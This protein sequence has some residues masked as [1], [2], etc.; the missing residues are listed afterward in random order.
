MRQLNIFFLLLV[1]LLMSAC[2]GV[3][4]FERPALSIADL[5]PTK[6]ARDGQVFTLKL[7][8]DN[9]NMVALPIEG[10]DYALN[11][12]GY[13]VASG[14]SNKASRIPA[15]GSGFVEIDIK[16]NVI[17]IFP[18]IAKTIMSGERNL[19]YGVKGSVKLDSIFVKEVPF[20]QKGEI[21]FNFGDLMQMR[22]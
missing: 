4:S 20:D 16:A 6:F 2:A 22:Q 8:V 17:E 18:Q 11:L 10:L 1:T 15:R 7:K 14:V 5:K 9:P 13:E 12:A 3:T 21:P 19:S